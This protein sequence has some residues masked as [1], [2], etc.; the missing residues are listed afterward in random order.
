MLDLRSGDDLLKFDRIRRTLFL[1]PCFDP[2]ILY[3]EQ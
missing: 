1:M 3:F 2:D